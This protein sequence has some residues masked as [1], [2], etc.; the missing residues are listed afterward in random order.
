VNNSYY[1]ETIGGYRFAGN[2][3]EIFEKFFGNPNPWTD[4][5]EFNGSDQYGS[6]FS[7]AFGGQN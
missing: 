7:D 5:Y 2:S 4:K 3:Y 6:L 1:I